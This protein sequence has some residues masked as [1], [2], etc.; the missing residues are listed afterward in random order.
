[1][2]RNLEHET[3]TT[4]AKNHYLKSQICI[5][6]KIFPF[7]ISNYHGFLLNFILPFQGPF[8]KY[9][10]VKNIDIYLKYRKKIIE[11]ASSL[12]AATSVMSAAQ[13]AS[14][15]ANRVNLSKLNQ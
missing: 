1:M 11:M 3:S 8:N 14:T 6:D 13:K 12:S 15:F 5:V 10:F 9:N 7:C 2:N 4:T